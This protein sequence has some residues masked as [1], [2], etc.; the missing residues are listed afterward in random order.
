MKQRSERPKLEKGR[1][2]ARRLRKK[3][4]SYTFDLSTPEGTKLEDKGRR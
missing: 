2:E 3:M 4:R 1:S